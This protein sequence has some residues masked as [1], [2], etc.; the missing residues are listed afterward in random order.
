MEKKRVKKYM[1]NGVKNCEE[2]VHLNILSTNMVKKMVNGDIKNTM[3]NVKDGERWIGSLINMEM[4]RDDK[5]MK[6]L[7]KTRH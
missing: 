5:Y 6:T 3:T 2:S 7:V 4:K 1:S